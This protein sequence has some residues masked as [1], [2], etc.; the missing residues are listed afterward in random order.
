MKYQPIGIIG[1]VGPLAAVAF[2]LRLLQLADAKTDQEYPVIFHYNNS[3]V[4][5]RTAAIVGNGADPVPSLQ[6]TLDTLV[7]A[8]A[9]VLAM[10][11]NTGH[12]L[13]DR[14]TIPSDVTY[15]NM[16]TAVRDRVLKEHGGATIG[17]L[18]TDGTRASGVYDDTFAS[19]NCTVLYPTKEDQQ[20]VMDAIYGIDGIKSGGRDVPR[21][22]LTSVADRLAERGVSLIIAACTEIPL[23]LSKCSVPIIDTIDVLAQAVLDA[24]SLPSE[25]AL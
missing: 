12:A 8:G 23:A 18:C 20:L 15:I 5:D 6:H 1:G 3:Q 13:I 21:E 24:S 25:S 19:T 17:V 4:P 10:P 16:L 22:K 2:E 9:K 7:A 14:L 11:C